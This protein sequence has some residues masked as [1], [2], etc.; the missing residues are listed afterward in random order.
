MTDHGK[1]IEAA[2]AAF[3]RACPKAA[4]M[5]YDPIRAAITAYRDAEIERLTAERDEARANYQF[6]V[7]R[8]A[9]EK[10]DGYRELGKR[11]ADA[12]NER[13]SL[14]AKLEAAER[15]A[16][17]L[18]WLSDRFDCH[19]DGTIG[20]TPSWH[21]TGSLRGESLREAID[22]ARGSERG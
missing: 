22:A 7:N 2:L 19:W 18:D 1:A 10:L 8:A 14:R 9:D 12:E 16:E 5:G 13:D 21:M 3:V 4:W 11:A 6:M 17:R 15:D 20:R